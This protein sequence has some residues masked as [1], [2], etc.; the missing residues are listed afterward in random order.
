MKLS[1][2]IAA[3]HRRSIAGPATRARPVAV[4]VLTAWLSL[5]AHAQSAAPEPAAAP[6]PA[7]VTAPPVATP[8]EPI[9]N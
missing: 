6:A 4:A 5:A 1:P 7:V 8:A 9:L 2:A 3:P